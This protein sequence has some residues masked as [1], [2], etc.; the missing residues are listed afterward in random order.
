MLP[1]GA[2]DRRSAIGGE[3]LQ[4]RAE[5]EVQAFMAL[6]QGEVLL[7]ESQLRP[8]DFRERGL[9]LF[10]RGV[11]QF[12]GR[13]VAPETRQRRDGN[14]VHAVGSRAEL[15]G[16]LDRLGE[17]LGDAER[18]GGLEVVEVGG[19]RGFTPVREREFHA[20][21]LGLELA[22][23]DLGVDIAAAYLDGPC[24]AKGGTVQFGD[25]LAGRSLRR[26]FLGEV[27]AGDERHHGAN[28]QDAGRPGVAPAPGL[29]LV[30]GPDELEEGA[31][32]AAIL[33]ISLRYGDRGDQAHHGQG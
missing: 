21:D 15:Q 30:G 28:G 25:G 3:A 24:R 31:G 6:G 16:E 12:A 9:E 26:C 17:F 29:R 2:E 7:V 22:L 32:R 27:R 8:A 5:V 13:T 33:A 20:V 10:R 19:R 18:L 14:V 11:G 1:L 4:D 23:Q